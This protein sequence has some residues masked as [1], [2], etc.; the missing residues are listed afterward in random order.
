MR[1]LMLAA[2][3]A[4]ATGTALEAAEPGRVPAETDIPNY[5]VI[6][7]DLAAAGQPTPEALR[8]L[9]QQGFRTI[10]NLRAASEPGVA[11]EKEIVES[12]GLRYVHV[13]MTAATFSLDDAKAVARVLDDEAAGPILLHCS[14]SNRVGGVW[15]VILAMRGRSLEQ[16]ETEGRTAGLSSPGMVEAARRVAGEAAGRRDP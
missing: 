10:V 6:A 9:K 15:A 12:Q 14:S 16:A 2:C 5:R 7:P 13:P 4:V 1:S 3:V 11:E 8:K